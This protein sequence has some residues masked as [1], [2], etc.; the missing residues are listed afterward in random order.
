MKTIALNWELGC[1]KAPDTPCEAYVSARVPGNVQLDWARAK[2]LPD[3]TFGDNYKQYA[4]MEDLYWRYRAH[5]VVDA[6]A[7]CAV[8]FFNGIDYAYRISVNGECLCE[9]AG[10]FTPVR[11]DI[12]RYIGQA[13][14]VEVLILPVPKR[15]DIPDRSQADHSV[16]PPVSYGWDW[17]PRLIPSGLFEPA[18]IE[19]LPA[20][21]AER[22]DLSYTLNEDRSAAVLRV[23]A[24]IRQA[25]EARFDLL[26]PEGNVVLQQTL[27][28]DGSAVQAAVTFAKPRLWWCAGH[29]PQPVYTALLHVGS[30]TLR[31]SV[32]FRTVRLVMN[33]GAWARPSDFPKSRSD[34]PITLELNGRRIF[35]KGSNW[36]PPEVFPG[37]IT[38]E[39]YRPLVERAA[40][41]H[42]NIFRVWGGGMVGKESFFDCCDRLGIMVWQEFP[43][44]CNNYPDDPEYLRVLEQEAVSILRRARTHPSLVMWCGGNELFNSWSGMT[45]QSHALRLLDKLCY[46]E[47]RHTPFIMTSPLNGMGHGNYVNL[48]Y[49]GKET[50]GKLIASHN[51]AYTEFGSPGASPADYLRSFMSPED[52][53]NPRPGSVWEDHH[54]FNAWRED[55][56]LRQQEIAYYFGALEGTDAKVAATERIQS[57]CYQLLFEEMRRQWPQCSMA[58]NWCYNE[59]W[60]CAANNSLINWPCKPKPA[61]YAVQ[62]ALRPQSVTAR[63]LRIRYRP[64][65]ELQAEIWVMNDAMEALAGDEVRVF[66]EANGHE[67]ALGSFAFAPIAA[68]T[69][70]K[71]FQVVF[72]LPVCEDR[73][74]ALVLRT[75]LRPDL[76][77]RYPL[78]CWDEASNPVRQN[79]LNV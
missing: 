73:E 53:G 54:A 18:G 45:E 23:D 31:R 1:C 66:L 62:A 8:L 40:E 17:H 3:Y 39:T 57:I 19:L 58:L 10:L 26:D 71:L 51:T 75:A 59:P 49:D 25:A 76:G 44:S 15:G 42:M 60:P 9:G 69:N 55:T 34:A 47:D 43:L 16:K 64:G 21:H 2:G 20:A 61:Y 27:R 79:I 65:E 4:F 11:L 5:A 30:H 48:D 52:Y 46:E 32:G 74:A 36:V 12:N 38:E 13:I 35:A 78:F 33:E 67:E 29:G 7:A 72:P 56:W 50:I 24:R 22:F 14:D 41:A 28:A 37:I 77:N 63:L 70:R 68:Q 6:D